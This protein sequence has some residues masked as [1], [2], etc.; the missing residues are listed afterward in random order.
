MKEKIGEAEERIVRERRE[1]IGKT[2]KKEE[3]TRRETEERGQERGKERK[4]SKISRERS[5]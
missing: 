5:C 1:E 3:E 4:T 2:Q